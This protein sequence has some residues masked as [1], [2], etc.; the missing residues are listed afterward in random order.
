[1]PDKKKQL[2]LQAEKGSQ[3]EYD[4]EALGQLEQ[5]ANELFE[6]TAK[7]EGFRQALEDFFVPARELDVDAGFSIDVYS[8]GAEREQGGLLK[9]YLSFCLGEE[10]NA[11]SISNIKEII[12]PTYITAV[13]RTPDIILGVSSLRGTIL[14]VLDLR[15]LLGLDAGDQTR[16]TRILIVDLKDELLGLF[17]DEVRHVIR[18]RD[19]EI[20][21]PPAMF[22]RV[23]IEHLLGVG[24]YE[25]AMYTLLD[26]TSLLLSI[27]VGQS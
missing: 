2:K 7:D 15:R 5:M 11:V 20:E 9:E 10:L 21:P 13:P 3:E 14:P 22:G 4:D 25:G 24:R 18:L 19:D 23:D 6:Y 27:K 1:V 17:V 8:V 12:K 16:K 26:L